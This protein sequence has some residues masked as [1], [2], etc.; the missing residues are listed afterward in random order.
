[1][2]KIIA[3]L[4]VFALLLA[5][6]AFALSCE[7]SQ[8]ASGAESCYTDVTLSPSVTGTVSAGTVMV[9]D[10][11]SGQYPYGGSL[12]TAGA[13]YVKVATVSADTNKVAGVL[14]TSVDSS[15]RSD[16]RLLVRGLGDAFVSGTVT[17]GD[18]LVVRVGAGNI[19]G[20]LTKLEDQPNFQNIGTALETSSTNTKKKVF[21]RVV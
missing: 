17:S 10:F 14:Q 9:Y 8:A 20:A 2:K 11:T 21:V 1:M 12:A 6:S 15:V 5:P 16:V 13:V 7:T 19:N 4:F 18:P 3:L